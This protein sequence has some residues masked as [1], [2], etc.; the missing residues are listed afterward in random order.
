L[1][2]IAS[3]GTK[4]IIKIVDF[5]LDKDYFFEIKLRIKVFMEILMI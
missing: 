1:W 4:E 2:C 5:I 3:L